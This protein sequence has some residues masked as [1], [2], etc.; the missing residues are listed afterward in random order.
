MLSVSEKNSILNSF[1]KSNYK[2][3]T[4]IGLVLLCNVLLSNYIL[5]LQQKNQQQERLHQYTQSITN[6]SAAQLAAYIYNNQLES[7]QSHIS[8]LMQQQEI[9]KISIYSDDGGLISSEGEFLASEQT[10]ASA[11]KVIYKGVDTGFLVIYFSK[12]KVIQSL[13]SSE[14]IAQILWGSAAIIFICLLIFLFFPALSQAFKRKTKKSD[15]ITAKTNVY[16]E[17]YPLAKQLL[18]NFLQYKV[19]DNQ[20]KN[21]FG[22]VIIKANWNQ[23]SADKNRQLLSFFNRFITTSRFSLLSLKGNYLQFALTHALNQ[24]FNHQLYILDTCLKKLQLSPQ[25]LVHTRDIQMPIV[26]RFFE[27]IETGIWHEGPNQETNSVDFIQ[28]KQIEIEDLG[29]LELLQLGPVRSE[30]KTAIERQCRF[31]LKG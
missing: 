30:Q 24:D 29:L 17:E 14:H 7:L 8:Q 19:T 6:T 11:T 10:Q 9:V 15:A 23:S 18:K 22:T 13:S 2:M 31:L 4:L 25:I 3:L 5:S 27:I 12:A 1:Q 21:S 20:S 26:E 16:A 28:R